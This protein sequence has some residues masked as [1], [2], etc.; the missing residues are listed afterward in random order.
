MK[1]NNLIY[2][3]VAV[4]AGALAYIIYKNAKKKPAVTKNQDGSVAVIIKKANEDPAKVV[5]HNGDKI[6]TTDKNGLYD[7]TGKQIAT[8]NGGLFV[9]ESGTPVAAPDGSPLKDITNVN[10]ENWDGQTHT[11]KSPNGETFD[12]KVY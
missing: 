8:L 7:S 12:F 9:D 11:Y 10:D 4:G 3:G 5:N 2:L 1:K 6:Y